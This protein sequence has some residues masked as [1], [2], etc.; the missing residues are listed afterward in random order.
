ME[1]IYAC[2]VAKLLNGRDLQYKNNEG[3][4]KTPNFYAEKKI[5]YIVYFVCYPMMTTIIMFVFV[6][7][8]YM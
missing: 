2:F 7:M 4:I 8:M 1:Q 3:E 6:S 5:V